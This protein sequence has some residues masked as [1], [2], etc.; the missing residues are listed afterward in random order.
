MRCFSEFF[1]TPWASL[2]GPFWAHVDPLG[3]S[4]W[5][6]AG[7]NIRKRG[8]ASEAWEGA[9]MPP[10]MC[11]I[12]KVSHVTIEENGGCVLDVGPA[13]GGLRDRYFKHIFNLVQSN[14]SRKTC[15]LQHTLWERQ[16][17]F[18]TTRQKHVA[19]VH[20]WITKHQAA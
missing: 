6:M 13:F 18:E 2:S 14:T 3:G 9:R 1:R 5:A 4:S 19:Q 11:V 12:R 15:R 20:R 16:L 17:I 8:L 10:N 7:H